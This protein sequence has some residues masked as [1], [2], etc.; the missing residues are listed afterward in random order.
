MGISKFMFFKGVYT[1]FKKK[2]SADIYDHSSG[3][4]ND[5]VYCNAGYYLPSHESAVGYLTE[6]NR[7]NVH[8]V[9]DTL[10]GLYG[11]N[12]TALNNYINTQTVNR[13][14]TNCNSYADWWMDQFTCDLGRA[15]TV[16]LRQY[17]IKVCMAGCDLIHTQGNDTVLVY[18]PVQLAGTN[19]LFNNFTDVVNFF[20]AALN[21]NVPVHPSII[22]PIDTNLIHP[23]GSIQD[24]QNSV[25]ANCINHSALIAEIQKHR[26]LETRYR[27]SVS[28][29]IAKYR[30][31]CYNS[32]TGIETFNM[33][34]EL[35]E[36]YY[37][38]YYYDRAG[39]LLK[40]VP[41]EGVHV[42]RGSDSLNS[43]RTYREIYGNELAHAGFI[44][45]HHNKV[46]IYRYN[47]LEKTNS[48]RTP[49]AGMSVT[50]YDKLGRVALLQNARQL[51]NRNFTYNTYDVQGR[52]VE[53]GQ[54]KD[55]ISSGPDEDYILDS[56]EQVALNSMVRNAVKDQVVHTFYDT[57][58][59]VLIRQQGINTAMH[60]SCFEQENVRSRIS[61][62]T[63]Y[64]ILTND[65]SKYNTALHYDYDIHGNVR[66]LIQDIPLLSNFN[67][68]YMITRYDYDL[69]SGK[70]NK[71]TYQTGMEE[72]FY[73]RY[74]YDADNRITHVFTSRD[75]FFWDNDAKYF[76]YKHG[77]LARIELGDKQVQGTDFAYT[78]QGWV[79]CINIKDTTSDLGDDGKNIN[80]NPN[81]DFSLDAYR[82]MINYY[83]SDYLAVK[84]NRILNQ[85][86]PAFNSLYNGNIAQTYNKP[87][88]PLSIL[89]SLPTRNFTDFAAYTYQY[90]QL[91]R[92]KN[93]NAV[94]G[95]KILNNFMSLRYDRDG[96]IDSLNRKAFTLNGP[97]MDRLKYQYYPNNNRLKQVTD[98][99][100]AG[101]FTTD[102]DNQ[103]DV[104][105][106]QYDN[107]GNLTK[108]KSE[109]I[110]LI[111]WT[112][113]GKV[114]HIRR[115][116][117]CAKANI[118]FLYDPLGNRLVK[119]SYNCDIQ[120][121]EHKTY[122][123]YANDAQ[124]NIMATY[125][126]KYFADSNKYILLTDGF[127]IYGSSRLGVLNTTLAINKQSNLPEINTIAVFTSANQTEFVYDPVLAITGWTFP[128]TPFNPTLTK[129][130]RILGSKS[131]EL[132][133][134][135]GNVTVTLSDRKIA[136]KSPSSPRTVFFY[137]AEVKSAQ[138][139]YPFGQ[140]IEARSSASYKYRFG[141]NGKENDNEVKGVGDQQ[142]Y[143]MRIYDPRL[144]RFLSVDPRY[145]I[146]TS[147]STYCYAANSPIRYTD[148]D[149]EGPGDRV[150]AAIMLTRYPG[151]R[152]NS[153]SDQGSGIRT[154]YTD[155]AIKEVDCA[156]FVCRVMAADL[157]TNGVKNYVRETFINF[158][159][160]DKKFNKSSLPT[161]GAIAVW[162]GIKKDN[163]GKYVKDVKGNYVYG[164]HTGIVSDVDEKN[165]Y[166]LIHASYRRI[167][168]KPEVLENP[169]YTTSDK[170]RKDIPLVGFY[171]PKNE[172]TDGKNVSI[173][174]DTTMN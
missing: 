85:H 77:P 104:N 141:Y 58:Y 148:I 24:Y 106:Y 72:Q 57:L 23:Y 25:L 100:D 62:V 168:N 105:N 112:L 19:T 74:N 167:D 70:V 2:I 87:D 123:I 71:A 107:I 9:R 37:T 157:I 56:T 99:I 125:T 108:D 78:L 43:I 26:I 84:D 3:A 140:I 60:I 92:L 50:W 103:S 49:D 44:M 118:D 17:L 51:P 73:H 147:L 41:P 101:D 21:C 22:N 48:Q 114:K 8:F 156:E 7:F 159:N 144:G 31:H 124:G 169:Y 30:Q 154:K 133:D 153:V 61:S 35:N 83:N 95:D 165:N 120:N 170:Y 121:N 64:N 119:L 42:I 90:D 171:T 27:D 166:K 66:T 12:L 36:Y 126:L 10:L 81:S 89:N 67:R 116:S 59:Y 53:T 38:L 80:G 13:C 86:T 111:D 145:K 68:R 122:T 45:P 69:V 127:P 76:Y 139:Y 134:Y 1:F 98:N 63:Y 16:A 137:F 97:L 113:L 160:D 75:G 146:F 162:Y 47:S 79:K 158:I 129:F 110:D 130:N 65:L 163:N 138:D 88:I 20:A 115:T 29:L 18:H 142:D 151:I 93:T 135:L 152:Y 150:K 6:D 54:I 155:V 117:G 40:T 173:N 15:D 14:D 82:Y 132:S 28:N 11:T 46:S 172:T 161:K 128:V 52:V 174:S 33:Q 32:L 164:F 91:N 102:F 131:Y 94:V 5:Y 39:N 55:A 4:I 34:Y 136:A 96:N 149:G 109:N 143:G